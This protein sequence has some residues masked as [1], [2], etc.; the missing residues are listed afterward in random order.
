MSADIVICRTDGVQ[1]SMTVPDP[2]KCVEFVDNGQLVVAAAG[3]VV[4]YANGAW[5]FVVESP[6]DE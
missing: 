3:H 1:D 6:A 2:R 5:M 4:T